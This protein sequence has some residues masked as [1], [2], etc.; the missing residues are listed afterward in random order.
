MIVSV[1]AAV[2]KMG[3]MIEL[4]LPGRLVVIWL[5]QIGVSPL[6]RRGSHARVLSMELNIVG[7]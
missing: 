7:A 2:Y 5:L 4:A 1:A 6:H 3:I